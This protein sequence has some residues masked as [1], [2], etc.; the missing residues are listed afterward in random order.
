HRIVLL[1]RDRG[2]PKPG[3]TVPGYGT[4]V[5]H[6]NGWKNDGQTNIDE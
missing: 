4:Q 6:T 2:C 3:C 1:S 5:H